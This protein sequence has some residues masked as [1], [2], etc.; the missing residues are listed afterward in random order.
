M[1]ANHFTTGTALSLNSFGHGH[2]FTANLP[3]RTEPFGLLREVK[4][5]P[6]V[7]LERPRNREAD[8]VAVYNDSSFI[9]PTR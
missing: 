5:D 2:V 6:K 9:V 3:I 8:S 4:L 1:K 7:R